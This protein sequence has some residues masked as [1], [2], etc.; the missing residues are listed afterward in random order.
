MYLGS[1]ITD[2][3]SNE[4]ETVKRIGLRKK[5]FSD[6]DKLFKNLSMIMMAR[7]RILKCFVW[8][9]LL[10]GYEA[11]TIRKDLRRKLYAAEM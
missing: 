4:K 10:Y 6:M 11:W 2:Q 3:G 9:K 7:V 5:A 8:L 1:T